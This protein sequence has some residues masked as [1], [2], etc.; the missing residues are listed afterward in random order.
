MH[1]K[2][3]NLEAKERIPKIIHEN[4]KPQLYDKLA[5]YFKE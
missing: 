1:V 2:L 4:E 5:K 3:Q